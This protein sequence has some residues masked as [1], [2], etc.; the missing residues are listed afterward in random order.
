MTRY[1]KKF[2]G[3]P[4]CGH[5]LRPEDNYCSRCGQENRDLNVPFEHLAGELVEN[6]LHLDTA[7]FRTVKALL[8]RPGLLT[9]HFN[10][11]KRKSFVAPVRLYVLVSFVFFF[12]AGMRTGTHE[13]HPQTA[14]NIRFYSIGSSELGGM[15]ESQLDSLMGARSLEK[16][17]FN[18]YVVRQLA[19][20]GSGGMG[21]FEHLLLRNVS[22][23]MFALMPFFGFLL[24]MF[25]RKRPS[26]YIECLIHSIHLHSFYFLLLAAAVVVS[27]YYSSG[28]VYAATLLVVVVYCSL[29]LKTVYHQTWAATALKTA[30]LG[31]LYLFSISALFL[32]TAF[33]SVVVF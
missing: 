16:T 30:A 19:R 7:S 20:I 1:R 24:Y 12:L 17:R 18:R 14:L 13:A 28:F 11:G 3:C 33:I 5:P 6:T 29:S 26:R 8:L 10:Q 2:S 31:C 25:Y 27:W 21:D 4:N 32:A 9:V 23:M 15:S 22:Y